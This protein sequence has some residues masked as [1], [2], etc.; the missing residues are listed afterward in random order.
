[1]LNLSNVSKLDCL[2]LTEHGSHTMAERSSHERS[3]IS[4]LMQKRQTCKDS[5]NV[6]HAHT[7]DNY[8]VRLYVTSYTIFFSILSTKYSNKQ[9]FM[10]CFF[11]SVII[12]LLVVCVTV[13]PGN[14]CI[15]I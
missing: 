9:Y 5:S 15:Q 12:V 7:E 4:G 11:E 1:M 10:T 8:T 13:V 14:L 2:T 6:M 3:D